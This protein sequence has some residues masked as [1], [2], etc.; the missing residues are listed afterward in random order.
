VDSADPKA[1]FVKRLGSTANGQIGIV[2]STKR[3]PDG[4]LFGA[5]VPVR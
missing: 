5:L 2:V 3:F 4:E 1:L